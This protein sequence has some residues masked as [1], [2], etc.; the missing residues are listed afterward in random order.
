[1]HHRDQKIGGPIFAPGVEVRALL[2]DMLNA[3]MWTALTPA[4][5]WLDDVMRYYLD[6]APKASPLFSYYT[7]QF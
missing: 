5:F 2:E 7:G 6:K 1:M 3:C 4:I